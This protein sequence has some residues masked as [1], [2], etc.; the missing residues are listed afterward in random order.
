MQALVSNSVLMFFF[1]LISSLLTLNVIGDKDPNL[2]RD[3]YTKWQESQVFIYYRI[4]YFQKFQSEYPYPDCF[5]N[6]IS[7]NYVITATS[8]FIHLNTFVEI[9]LDGTSSD[10][11]LFKTDV[12]KIVVAKV[13]NLVR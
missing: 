1:L 5:G 7:V 4:G 9:S 3:F 8:C 12:G 10:L 11:S 6:L 2:P 13:S